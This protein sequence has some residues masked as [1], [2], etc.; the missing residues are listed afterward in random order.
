MKKSDLIGK[1]WHELTVEEKKF[2]RKKRVRVGW[3]VENLKQPDWCIY[4][5]AL[6]C[7][8]G[9]WSLMGDSVKINK[10]F[11]KA[12]DYYVKGEI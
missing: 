8:L 1:Y 3:V 12:C 5:N 6:A 11:C 4:P 2:L 9:C 7:A 10:K